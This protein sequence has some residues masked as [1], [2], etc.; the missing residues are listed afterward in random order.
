[1]FIQGAILADEQWINFP[2][3][4]TSKGKKIVLV[5]GDDEYRSEEMLP[6][7]AK[8]LSERH[9]FDCTVLFALDE[10]GFIVPDKQDNIAGLHLLKQADLMV[11]FIRMRS[12]PDDQI[13]HFAEYLSDGK[14]IIAIRTSTH[15]FQLPASSGYAHWSWRSNEPEG[16]F[17]RSILGETWINHHGNHGK[18]SCRGLIA[19]GAAQHPILRGIKD[20]DIWGPTDVYGVRLPLPGDC[21]P[22]VLGQVLQGMSATDAP[23]DGKKNDPMMPIAW[24]KTYHNGAGKSGRVFTTTMGSSQDFLNEGFRR[25]MINSCYWGLQLDEQIPAKSNVELIGNYVTSPFKF[26]GYVRNKRPSITNKE[27]PDTFPACPFHRANFIADTKLSA[28]L[29]RVRVLAAFTI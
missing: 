16:G 10:K 20:G 13:K 28:L 24:T 18:E 23:V 19:P 6:Q 4:G 1:M 5:S 3:K 26:G 22:I 17:G 15:P 21:K 2:A 14:P 11:L 25:L 9:G 12:L 7:M 29:K 8:I 27:T